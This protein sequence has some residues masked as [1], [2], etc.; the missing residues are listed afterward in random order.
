ME[1]KIETS[2]QIKKSALSIALILGGGVFAS[3]AKAVLIP[4]G[5]PLT[6]LGNG[7]FYGGSIYDVTTP[8][9]SSIAVDG[10]FFTGSLTSQVYREGIT[11]PRP[12]KLEFVYQFTNDGTSTDTI[13]R[14]TVDGFAGLANIYADYASGTGTSAPWQLTRPLLPT[15][16]VIGF[17]FVEVD[18]GT[19]SDQLIINTNVTQWALDDAA[20]QDGENV[21]IPAPGPAVPEPAS[22]TLLTL[23]LSALTL[24]RSKTR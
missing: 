1:R 2:L 15:G 21:S 17:N 13:D 23:A 18:A 6:P 12:G 7:A 10:S 4:P 22:A 8:F 20:L 11:D 5:P 16:N 3:T 14:F 24:R 9:V 19:N